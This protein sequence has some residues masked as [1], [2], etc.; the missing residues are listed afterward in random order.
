LAEV[1]A[2]MGFACPLALR[3]ALLFPDGAPSASPSA[4]WWPW[5]FSAFGLLTCS[6]SFDWISYR[7]LFSGLAALTAAFGATFV[8][9][10]R[11]R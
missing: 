3:A 6:V 11:Q 4:R 7:V 1:E 10:T 9:V 8:V 2:A 5:L